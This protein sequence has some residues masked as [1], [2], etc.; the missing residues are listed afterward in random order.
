[1]TD[2]VLD[3]DDLGKAAE[4]LGIDLD[5]PIFG[6]EDERPEGVKLL[7]EAGRDLWARRADWIR[8]PAALADDPLAI[9]TTTKL[10]D[11]APSRHDVIG[12]IRWLFHRIERGPDC[13]AIAIALGLLPP[14]SEDQALRSV[15]LPLVSLTGT[16]VEPSFYQWTREVRPEPYDGPSMP[17]ALDDVVVPA[18]AL[19]II[20]ALQGIEPP[21]AAELLQWL[22][23]YWTRVPEVRAALA[24][25]LD[26]LLSAGD[27]LAWEP[28]RPVPPPWSLHELAN[29][30]TVSRPA[31]FEA[32]FKVRESRRDSPPGA[33]PDG[34]FKGLHGYLTP[35][36]SVQA[37]R[38][39][40]TETRREVCGRIVASLTAEP[41]RSVLL[42]GPHGSGKSSLS[43]VVAGILA[44]QGIPVF[45]GSPASVSAGATYVHELDGRI[46]S[47]VD[48]L[49]ERDALWVAPDFDDA[50]TLGR[51][52]QSSTNFADRLSPL[53]AAGQLRLIAEVT[54]D[55]YSSLLR[56][57]PQLAEL[58]ETVRLVEPSLDELR[59]IGRHVAETT[60]ETRRL[61]PAPLDVAFLD[62]AVDVT[63]AFL[64]NLA[65][66]GALVRLITRLFEERDP[67]DTTALG[68]EDAY[69]G[70]TAITGIPRHL[71]DPSTPLDVG[72]L[73]ERISAQVLGQDEAVEV[74]TERI[75]MVKAGVCAPGRP[76]GVFLFV[77]PTGTGKTELVRVLAAELFGAKERVIR[78]DMSELDFV[79]GMQRLLGT[80]RGPGRSLADDV[81][82]QPFSVVLLDEFEKADRRIWD[83]F[84]QVFDAGR[85]TDALGR[86][87]DFRQ[88]I[89]VATSNLGAA[90]AGRRSVGFGGGPQ[91]TFSEERLLE[92]VRRAFRPELLNRFDRVVTFTPLPRDVM[93]RL[94]RIE[95]D[96]VFASRGFDSLDWAVEVDESAIEFLLERGFTNELG[97][98]PLRRAVERYLTG[99]LAVTIASGAS[100]AGSQFLLVSGGSRDL[101]MRFVSADP[102]PAPASAPGRRA[103]HLTLVGIAREPEGTEDQLALLR[104]TIGSLRDQVDG[105]EW[106]GRRSEA[107]ATLSEPGFWDRD[108]RFVILERIETT[109]GIERRLGGAAALLQRIGQSAGHRRADR[110]TSSG[111]ARELRQLQLGIDAVLAGEPGD[112]LVLIESD[113][114]EQGRAARDHLVEMY[115]AWAIGV[116]GSAN[117]LERDARG[118]RVLLID[119]PGAARA[120]APENGLHF[121]ERREQRRRIVLAEARVRVV[122]W[123]GGPADDPAAVQ[124]D[125]DERNP[126]RHYQQAPTPLVIDEVRAY[127]TGRLEDVLAGR[128][129][130]F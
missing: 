23:G 104:D 72:R 102:E 28:D 15:V 91:P 59:E 26:D 14:V 82:A 36:P 24:T 96:A 86:T 78:I 46:K 120:L 73:R 94:V 37:A 29:A 9:E 122:P 84:L 101:R 110:T 2:D 41:P 48:D 63:R 93:R 118:R 30:A 105:E 20:D 12:W 40:V 27:S 99:P 35:F 19:R 117:R 6:D 58:L 129:D 97:A 98:R 44:E 4:D 33:A 50:S 79:S 61:Q 53:I 113:D 65:Q 7:E 76:Y 119:A 11:L 43:I 130:L 77:G 47:I 52:E 103:A 13:P 66:P 124:I 8:S 56:E 42:V 67:A 1:M 51:H 25:L 74:L 116:G 127:R 80:G 90:L 106:Q 111:L 54:E 95:V 57:S 5:L 108:D 89:I 69:R 55:G 123:I 70:V 100:P 71:V 125:P 115:A 112:A 62:L 22:N 75:A 92:A 107:F 60:V 16:N 68:S 126:V 64:P 17:V 88:T 34:R 18:V 39:L 38:V 81:R 21:A 83:L 49:A 87:I 128:F 85:L 45:I 114:S 121:F 3:D 32:A 31:L 10:K 109:D